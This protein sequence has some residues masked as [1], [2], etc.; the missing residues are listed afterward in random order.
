MSGLPGQ[1]PP[2]EAKHRHVDEILHV[3]REALLGLRFGSVTLTVHEDRVVQID[4]TTKTRLTPA[5]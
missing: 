1:S 2:A 4:V 3:L 5:D